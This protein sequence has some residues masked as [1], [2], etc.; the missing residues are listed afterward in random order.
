MQ[1]TVLPLFHAPL[2]IVQRRYFMLNYHCSIS[3]GKYHSLRHQNSTLGNSCN[4]AA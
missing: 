1:T 4:L 2:Y 3:I